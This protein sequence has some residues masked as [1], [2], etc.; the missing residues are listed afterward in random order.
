MQNTSNLHALRIM[1]ENVGDNFSR[2]RLIAE[3]GKD[4][5]LITIFKRNLPSE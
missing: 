3:Q 2:D 4:P 5:D 1:A